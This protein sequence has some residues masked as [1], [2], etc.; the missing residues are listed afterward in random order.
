M[1]LGIAFSGG[2]VR[3]FAHAGVLKYLQEHGITAGIVSGTSAGAIVATAYSMG[4]SPDEMYDFFSQIEPRNIKLITH[5]TD[6]GLVS[7]LFLQEALEDFFGKTRLEDLKIPTKVV[8]ADLDNGRAR[9]FDSGSAAKIVLASCSIPVIFPPVEMDGTLYVDGGLYKNFP[10]STIR[11]YCD[12]VI[13]INI[14]SKTLSDYDLSIRNI[15]LRCWTHIQE[16]NIVI[17]R[18]SCDILIESNEFSRYNIFDVKQATELY[19]LGY[20]LASQNEALKQLIA[21][22]E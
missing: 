18:N 5:R 14:G 21:S 12:T 8:T 22:Y 10:V 15:G 9:V 20:S 11:D 2:G 13:G 7:S 3:G 19:Q 6:G 16:E 4:R 17:D 1:K